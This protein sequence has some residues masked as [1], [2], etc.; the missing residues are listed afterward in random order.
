MYPSF[1]QFGMITF[2]L[3]M[4]IAL[5]ATLLPQQLLFRCGL[6]SKMRQEQ[7]ALATGQFCARWLFRFIPF[8]KVECTTEATGRGRG[9]GSGS[10]SDDLPQPTV[11]V[12]NHSSMLDVFILLAHD[13][14]LRGK[15][16]RPIKIIYVRTF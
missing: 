15:K 7:W 11:W 6:I 16:K 3:G 8:C 10:G 9:S 4:C 13:L 14:K 2:I 12:C 1:H 5:P